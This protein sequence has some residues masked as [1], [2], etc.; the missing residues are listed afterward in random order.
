MNVPR[1]FSWIVA[2][3]LISLWFRWPPSVLS[4]GTEANPR[5]SSN[6]D[7]HK[8]KVLVRFAPKT[9]G[10]QRNDSERRQIL[11][12]SIGGR[13]MWNSRRLTGLSVV[14]L[15][16][17]LSVENA[18]AAL[19]RRSD[20]VYAEPNY[21]LYLASNPPNDPNFSQLWGLH[22]ASDND[23]DA[24]EAWDIATDSDV[25]VAV[26]DTG[27]DY[28]HP[29]LIGQMW[30]NSAELN[31]TSGQDDDY[32][33]YVDDV[34]GWDFEDTVAEGDNDP[35]D[36]SYHGTHVAG[37]IG[38][39]GNNG[40]GVT[41]VCWDVTIM[42]LKIFPKDGF[43]YEDEAIAAIEY[44][45][46]KGAKIINCSW[47]GSRRLGTSLQD[48][49]DD[50]ND[51]GVLCV[52]AAGNW[53]QDLDDNNEDTFPPACFDSNNIISVMAT[54]SSDGIWSESLDVGS[55]WGDTSVDLAA[56]GD[57]IFST[58]P[59]FLTPDINDPNNPDPNK[60]IELHYSYDNG[61]SMAAPYVSGA[62]ALV[63]SVAP[64]LS[65][66]QVRQVILDSVDELTSLK[67]PKKCVTEGR[68]NLFNALVL[69]DS[70][71][72]C[73][74]VNDA[75]D[76]RV[77]W[78]TERGNLY[79]TGTLTQSGTPTA[80][81]SDEFRIQNSVGTDVA[82]INQSTGNMVISGSASTEQTNFASAS[83]F[84]VK[85]DS[86]NVIAYID[87][88]GNLYLKGKVIENCN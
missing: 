63:W 24:P 78:F 66:L 52:C 20:V 54:N 65:H 82:I 61:T 86:G 27:I 59:T 76:D 37:I 46:D 48:A 83:H 18:I 56:P 9:S 30:Q 12:S 73:F 55:N 81:G 8:R 32:N 11:Q 44:A 13:L 72:A 70:Y 49:I 47:G 28:G 16:R 35:I 2:I 14:E 75:S 45:V 10:L 40:T 42:N 68:L 88:S 25:V 67:N 41:G 17:G 57:D 33:T 21:R 85:D 84:V 29:D 64:S 77:A 19:R 71:N 39:I 23:I 6:F 43:S 60:L 36:Y 53:Y 69:A 51:A 1:C 5:I 50:A 38:A 80:S 4:Q 87:T 74:S 58:T 22:D 34:N 15:P 79:L 7:Y 31:G 26:I 3:V 62:C